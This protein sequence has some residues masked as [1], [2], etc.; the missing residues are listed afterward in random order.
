MQTIN[1][2]IVTLEEKLTI[3]VD[4]DVKR[5]LEAAVYANTA[6][7]LYIDGQLLVQAKKIHFPFLLHRYIL[8]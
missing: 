7:R 8:T 6:G 4:A 3:P 1:N 2:F 5:G